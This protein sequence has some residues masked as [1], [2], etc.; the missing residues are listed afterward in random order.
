MKIHDNVKEDRAVAISV[1]KKAA[2]KHPAKGF[3]KNCLMTTRSNVH[4][5]AYEGHTVYGDR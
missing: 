1:H 3:G 2:K 5:S 4:T